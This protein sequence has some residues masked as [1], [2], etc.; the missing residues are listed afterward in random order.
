MKYKLEVIAF[1]IES[2]LI[3]QENGADRIELCDNPFD[4]GTTPSYGMIRIA[5]QLLEIQLFPIIRPRGGDFLYNK[6][7]FD[8]MKIDIEKSKELG[9]DGVVIGLLNEDGAIDFKRTM[10]LV[11]LASP[12]EVTF[13][14]AFD[15]TKDPYDALERIIE[16]GCKRIL[17]SGLYPNVDA[18]KALLKSLNL[19][20]GN[21]I[22]IMPGSGLRSN[23]LKEIATF[24]QCFEF[25]SS[26]RIKKK[27]EMKFVN[28]NMNEELDQVI[29]DATEV[30]KMKHIL[31]QL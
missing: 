20:A 18:G 21:R 1:N 15:R 7:E 27:S 6:H 12:M 14:R 8:I 24:T 28:S 9:C 31:N 10:E 11:K 13:H 22:S 3:A 23:N 4:G 5:R 16:S 30:K 17:T 2:C 25:H 29:L 19:K 26:A